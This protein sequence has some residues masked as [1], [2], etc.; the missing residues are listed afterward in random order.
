MPTGLIEEQNGVGSR[1]DLAGDLVEVELHGFG[2][3]GRQHE[4]G[5][6]AAF[7]TD[8]TEQIGGLGPLIVSGPRT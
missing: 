3:A 6:G 4:G 8:G 5:A 7:R 1:R 2:V